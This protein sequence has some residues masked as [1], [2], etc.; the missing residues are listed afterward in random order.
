MCA[1]LPQRIVISVLDQAPS[2][3]VMALRSTLGTSEMAIDKFT[4]GRKRTRI[5]FLHG[6]PDEAGTG[7]FT[8]RGYQLEPFAAKQRRDENLAIT[9]S[10]VI[11]QSAVNLKGIHRDLERYA[12]KLLEFDCRLY[13]RIASNLN[14]QGRERTTVVNVIRKLDLP[15]AGLNSAERATFPQDQPDWEGNPLAPYVCVCDSSWSWDFLA[16]LIAYNSSGKPPNLHLVPEARTAAG[17]KLKLGRE[18][19]LLL[20]RAFEDCSEVHLEQMQDGLSGVSVFRAHAKVAG[21][22]VGKEWWSSYFV[23]IG[24][25]RKIA[26]EFEKY[27]AY[28]LRYIPFNLA[29]RLTLERC[30]LGARQGIIVGDFVEQS[31]ALGDSAKKGRSAH[32]LGTLFT[33]TMEAWRHGASE[34]DRSISDILSA[35]L[36][37][38]EIDIPETRKAQ[39]RA[40][41]GKADLDRIRFLLHKCDKK[42]VLV[43][44]V[45]GDLNASNILVRLSDAILIDFEKLRRDWPLLY[46][47]ASVEAGLLV[48]GFLDDKRD[49][50]VWLKSIEA[51]YQSEEMFEYRAPCHPK[52]ASAWFHDCV[53]VIRIHARQMELRRWQYAT[54][55]GLAL[56]KKS[57]NECIFDDRRDW[58]RAAAYVLGERILE[59]VVA[60]YNKGGV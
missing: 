27:Q 58:L 2:Q 4:E 52:D 59:F 6:L 40:L 54:A 19:T 47:A 31:E 55:L 28:A 41:G 30:G 34:A 16:Q 29:P 38:L 42:P 50:P 33:R 53:R 18:S 11:T 13:V 60:A 9:D 1:Q 23:K 45:H 35:E 10:V 25:R 21:A 44:T 57:C 22:L 48:G 32:A 12:R 14:L 8:K 7:A 36:L 17:K 3:E 15:G 39:I 51:L 20:R 24:A 26:R 37:R 46:D 56:V 49:I 5:C 43:G